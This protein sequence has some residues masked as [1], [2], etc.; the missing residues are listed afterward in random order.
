MNWFKRIFKKKE[1]PQKSFVN[2]LFIY[3]AIPKL[4]EEERLTHS[5]LGTEPDPL[6][7]WVACAFRLSEVHDIKAIEITTE[8]GNRVGC[9]EVVFY[10]GD[11]KQVNVA[12]D[13]FLDYLME[14]ED[15]SL[16]DFITDK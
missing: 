8:D 14:D 16:I 15:M 7:Q 3:K 1:I 12:Y 10:N 4:S 5:A 11:T 6:R 2:C 9:T 13:E